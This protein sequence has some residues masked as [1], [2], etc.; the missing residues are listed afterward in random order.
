MLFTHKKSDF[1]FVVV[2]AYLPPENSPWGRDAFS[3]FNHLLQ[4]IYTNCDSDALFILGDLNARVGDLTDYDNAVD[5]LP[6]RCKNIDNKIKSHGRSLIEFLLDSKCCM[7][8]GRISSDTSNRYTFQSVRGLSLVDYVLVP[9]DNLS[10]CSDMKVESCYDIVNTLHIEQLITPNC[11]L[12]D[13]ALLTMNVKMNFH[14]ME[15]FNANLA[16]D[17]NDD[18]DSG[19]ATSSSR[20]D[21]M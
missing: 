7:A 8:N 15:G 9:H 2:S 11:R 13:H 5:S 20:T 14:I 21:I 10:L 4:L 1:S 6:M 17:D 12:P 3:F 19:G 16:G 18:R